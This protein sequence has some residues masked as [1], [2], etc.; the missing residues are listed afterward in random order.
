MK[1]YLL[2]L[3]CACISFVMNAQVGGIV[4]QPFSPNANSHSNYQDSY[5][6]Q[7]RTI[8]TNAY[9]QDS[10]GEIYKVPIKVIEYNEYGVCRLAISEIC[11]ST[12]FGVQWTKLNMPVPVQE[13]MSITATSPLETQFTHKANVMGTIYY[14]DL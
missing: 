14:F 6:S 11:K 1:K 12:G 10:Y 7:Q 2:I 9:S 5:Q 8:R 13:C 4:Y 3:T